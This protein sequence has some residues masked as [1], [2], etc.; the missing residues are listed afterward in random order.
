VWHN[1]EAVA[2]RAHPTLDDDDE[3]EVRVQLLRKLFDLSFQEQSSIDKYRRIATAH[4]GVRLFSSKDPQHHED[5]DACVLMVIAVA[6]A[7]EASS[8]EHY[9]ACSRAE[10]ADCRPQTAS[11]RNVA[12]SCTIVVGFER[13]HSGFCLVDPIAFRR[14]SV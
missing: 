10:A 6:L 2:L 12:T 5:K 4:N 14:N 3:V 8:S 13:R 7:T 9:R 1:D 11:K